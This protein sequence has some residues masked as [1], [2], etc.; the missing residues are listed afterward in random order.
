MQSDY[1]NFTG[2]TDSVHFTA[3]QKQHK[4][5]CAGL[6]VLWLNPAPTSNF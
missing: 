5:D 2:K 6:L 3:M 4:E 1:T